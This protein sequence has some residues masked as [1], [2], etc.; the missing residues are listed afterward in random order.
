[1]KMT[2]IFGSF[3][4]GFLLL[5]TPVVYSIEYNH[6]QE[7]Q[8]TT[9][10]KYIDELKMIIS[11]GDVKLQEIIPMTSKMIKVIESNEYTCDELQD[12]YCD[13][14]ILFFMSFITIIGFIFFAILLDNVATAAENIGC[15]WAI[16]M[17]NGEYENP[18][19]ELCMSCVSE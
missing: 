2:I 17:R 13:F 1:M 16:K 10:N 9:I 3:L 15:E 8:K 12:I 14:M 5:M 19:S 11:S 6:V 7:T 4:A 18:F